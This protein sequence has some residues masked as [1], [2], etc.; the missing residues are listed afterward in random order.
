MRGGIRLG[1]FAGVPIVADTSAFALAFLF[2]IAVLIDLNRSGLSARSETTGIVSLVAGI[3]VLV[4]V[5]VHEL[6]H[7]VIAKRRGLAVREIHLYIFGGYSV[8]AGKSSPR[9]E[10]AISVVGPLASVAFGGLLALGV[11]VVGD[12][13][14]AGRALWALVLA[15]V[16]IGLFN[17]IPGWPLDGARILRG[18]LASGARDRVAATRIVTSIGRRA[19]WLA[20]LLGVLLLIM[21]PSLGVLTV[22]AGWFLAQTATV[23][24]RREELSVAFDGLVVADVMRPTPEAVSRDWTASTLLS[25]YDFGPSLRSLPVESGGRVV[26]VIGQDEIDAVAPSRWPSVRVRALM[27]AIGPDDIVESSDPLESLFL[28]PVGPGGQ[29]VVVRNGE[30]VGIVD[31]AALVSVLDG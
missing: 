16:A 5:V 18:A 31:R 27:V 19:G 23:A 12:T 1:R 15:N 25:R 8:I 11:L 22:V 28:R 3:V 17:L 6:S 21:S 29:D 13:S 30:V 10:I 14:V 4:S 7:S 24:G 9:D 2:G 20:M 26:G